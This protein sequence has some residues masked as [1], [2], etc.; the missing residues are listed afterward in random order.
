MHQLK[1]SILPNLSG[2]FTMKPLNDY[3]NELKNLYYTGDRFYSLGHLETALKTFQKALN[4]T[5]LINSSE[6]RLDIV[7]RIGLVHSRIGEY[8]NSIKY[9]DLALEI[10]SK[11]ED[12]GKKAS[13][14]NEKGENYYLLKD[15][16]AALECYS[17]ALT[18]FRKIKDI[19][20]IGKT[21][22]HIAKIYNLTGLSAK[23]LEY[24]RKSLHIFEKLDKSSKVNRFTIKINESISLHNMGESYFLLG[25]Y[26][27]AQAFL[28]LALD[29]RKKLWEDSLERLE[30]TV[31][32]MATLNNQVEIYPPKMATY[33]HKAKD[34]FHR[35]IFAQYGQDLINTLDLMEK[36]YQNLGQEKQA[37]N[38]HKQGEKIWEKVN[39][40]TS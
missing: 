17:Q 40:P 29:I 35:S 14:Y 3:Q 1:K 15:Y 19:V 34:G 37:N 18:I 27:Q 12:E 11:I 5:R 23:A 32:N 22:N 16:A 7:Y 26:R 39:S 28:Q 21:I 6:Q 2:V 8:L 38:Y 20:G 36:V 9:L 4:I 24:S 25:R 30:L 13:I 33:D 10:A 31:D